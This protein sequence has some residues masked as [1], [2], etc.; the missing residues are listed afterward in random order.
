[1]ENLI[2][3]ELRD[4]KGNICFT[5]Q[6]DQENRQLI[7]MFHQKVIEQTGGMLCWSHFR[8]PTSEHIFSKNRWIVKIS[9][10]CAA[11]S[12]CIEKRLKEYCDH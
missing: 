3:V 11:H 10:C 7:E 1:M 6:E 2:E 5:Q 12:N 9:C 8:L 4:R